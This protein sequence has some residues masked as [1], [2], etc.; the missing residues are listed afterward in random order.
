MVAVSR[1]GAN[2][3]PEVEIRS[4]KEVYITTIVP[5][6]DGKMITFTSTDPRDGSNIHRD[7][8]EAEL[9]GQS[10]GDDVVGRLRLLS[11]TRREYSVALAALASV[12]FRGSGPMSGMTEIGA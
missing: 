4:G 7:R 11:L 3:S 5:S 1:E 10:G 6:A 2:G 8:Y 12:C 9:R